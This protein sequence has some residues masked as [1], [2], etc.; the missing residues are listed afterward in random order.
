MKDFFKT[1]LA[2]A[3]LVTVFFVGFKFGTAKEK[4]K[5]PNFQEDV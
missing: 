3:F 1:L 2:I 4:S 5:I